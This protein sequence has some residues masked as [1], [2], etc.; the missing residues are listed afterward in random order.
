MHVADW[1]GFDWFLAVIVAVSTISGF[2]RG[3]L[4]SLF[5][6]AGIVAG[7]L[8]ATWQY[9]E[10]GGRLSQW[11][12]PLVTARMVAF[13]LIASVTLLC[14]TLAGRAVRKTA[15]A[16]GLGSFDRLGGAVY[17][18]LRGIVAGIALMMGIVTALPQSGWISGSAL[19]PYFLGVSHAVF[20][21]VPT[22][23]REQITNIAKGLQGDAPSWMKQN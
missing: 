17:G 15:K 9:M 20:F 21:V 3:F 12:H 10:L 16:V 8:L 18:F 19:A 4:R 13:L 22:D 7:V 1:N 23:L 14:F 6:L 2:L 11:I 5:G